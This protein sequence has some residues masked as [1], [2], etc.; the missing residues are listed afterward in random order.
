MSVQD[1]R[2]GTDD[3]PAHDGRRSRQQILLAVESGPVLHHPPA[4][5]D[6]TSSF[7]HLTSVSV[8]GLACCGTACFVSRHRDPARWEQ[9]ERASALLRCAGSCHVAPAV[10]G[11]P[12]RPAIVAATATPVVLERIVA[13][14]VTDLVDYQTTGGYS[15][16]ETART[17]GPEA[18]IEAV[19][20][21]ML[22]GRGGAAF[23]AG[24]KWRA[25]RAA[26]TSRGVSPVVVV[27]ADEGDPGAYIDRWLLED[28][29]HAVLEGAAIA[30]HA[31]GAPRAVVYVRAE[32]PTARTAVAAAAA[33]A[34]AAGA[35][36]ELEVQVIEGHGSYV[37][38]EETA[39]LDA[40]EGR[41]PR[42]RPRPPYP[43]E[44]GLHGRPTLVH[45]VETLAAVPWIV[46]NGADAYAAL[47]EGSS[48]GTKVLSLNS[49]FARPGLYEVELGIPVRRV[50]EELGGGLI[51]GNLA[52]V[53][54]GGPLAGVLPPSL[55]DTPL[56]IEDLRSVGADVGHGGVIAFDEQTGITVPAC[57]MPRGRRGSRCQRCVMALVDRSV[58]VHG[59]AET[60]TRTTCPY[61]GVGCELLVG[62]RDG[63][64]VQV[65][66]ALDAPVNRGHAC[67]KGRY[68][69]EF[70]HA[71]D[72]LSTPLVRDGD[73]LR[74]ASWDEA[75]TRIA[76]GFRAALDAHGPAS[77]GVL[78]SA[79][80]TNEENYLAQK[81]ARVVLGTNNVD[82]C[83]RVCHAPSAAALGAVFGTGAATS[84]FDD[85]ERAATILVCGA[86]VTE[87]HPVVG[88]RI[89]QAALRGANLIVIDPRRTEIAAL[90]DVHLRLQPGTNVALLNAMA[91]A[92][93]AQGLVDDAFVRNRVDGYDELRAAVADWTPELAAPV[94][95]VDAEQIRM[96]ARLV[97]TA[98]PAISFHGLGMTEHEQGT[99]GVI[100]IANLM[101]LTGNVGRP[102]TGVNP[103]RGQN[104][105]Q[106]AAHMGCEPS[107]L[108]GYQPIAVAKERFTE[109]WGAPVPELP[110]LDAMQ[111]LDAAAAGRLRALWV[112]GWD[113]ALTQPNAKATAEA[114]ERLDLLVVSDLFLD[115]TARR[116]ATVV[117]PAASAFEKDGTFMNGERRV[118]RVRAVV[119]P[120]T[121]TRTDADA[122]AA[123]AAA[124]GHAESFSYRSAAEVWD[125]IRR[126]WPAGAGMSYDRLD[127]PGG[128]QWPCPD[129]NHPGTPLLHT[130]TFTVGPRASLRVLSPRSPKEKATSELPLVLITGRDLYKFNAGTMTGRSATALLRATDVLE[131]SR[132][133]GEA[134][135][136]ANGD[137]VIVT[138]RYGRATL[139]AQITERVPPGVVFAT[140]TD[141][142]VNINDVTNDD[143]DPTTN[144][145]AYK[146]TA[147]SVHRA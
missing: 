31:V 79:R 10:G 64:I 47:G 137:D 114:L 74:E 29:P 36:G 73:T 98:R 62:A 66:P 28:D 88:A 44:R 130:N 85:I 106:G 103:L 55:L 54:I 46:R 143:R 84:S 140:F 71:A 128:L 120:P 65:R 49:L 1:G 107:R 145:P 68:G 113:L 14:P 126:V 63:R 124:M 129:V 25:V 122:I 16:L 23:P 94:C 22:R 117:L 32:Y 45:N 102:G 77:V 38:G 141:P 110:G 60:W 67:V 13:G 82:S 43:A 81:F 133:D 58:L 8:E 90:A 35:L 34:T 144:T 111:Q 12:S 123:V 93:I 42:V 69:F 53:L 118:Q 41:R 127:A 50:V 61:C 2:P 104:N 105:V 139:V 92:V 146:L 89:K 19:E 100:A 39:L 17:V 125:E 24:R 26:A 87:N 59:A 40:I 91:N 112:I 116:H 97:A 30:A 27:N 9:A 51:D 115:E 48:R 57:S 95:G 78:G 136:I 147:V 70:V 132:S 142:L 96:A 83:A 108:T 135:G 119:D 37:C 20:S 109:V 134:L 101:L 7:F 21:S 6:E 33:A 131:L 99:D 11:D 3:G 5:T 72:R 52:G 4:R 76:T 15:A 75:I 121:G 18:L 138:S 56:T 86:N 80:A